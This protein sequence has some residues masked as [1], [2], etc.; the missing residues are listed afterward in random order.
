MVR[1]KKIRIK[2]CF[3]VEKILLSLDLERADYLEKIKSISLSSF[4]LFSAA[5]SL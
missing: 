3:S 2:I 4:E 1:G 5:C